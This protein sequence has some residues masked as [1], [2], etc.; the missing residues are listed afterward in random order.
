MHGDDQ[1]DPLLRRLV[2]DSP[3]TR[4]A[5]EQAAL[6]LEPVPARPL[7]RA[8]DADTGGLGRRRQ[9]PAPIND[10]ASEYAPAAPAESRVTVQI[11]PGRLLGRLS[12]L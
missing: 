10:T 11:H 2:G 5:V 1:P 6:A 8:A 3:R 12:C 7:A 4:G 9:R